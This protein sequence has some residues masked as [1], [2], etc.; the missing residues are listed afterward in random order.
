MC[1]STA[2]ITKQVAQQG[3]Q[4]EHNNQQHERMSVRRTDNVVARM[5]ANGHGGGEIDM[6]TATTQKNRLTI[7]CVCGEPV[8]MLF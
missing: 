8:G 3:Q 2:E 4:D 6:T 1:R 5:G 7:C